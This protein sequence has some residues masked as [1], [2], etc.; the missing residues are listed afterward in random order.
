MVNGRLSTVNRHEFGMLVL[1]NHNRR[2]VRLAKILLDTMDD[3]CPLCQA[4]RPCAA[5]SC[6]TPPSASP[7]PPAGC[8]PSWSHP[9]GSDSLLNIH[10]IHILSTQHYVLYLLIIYSIS[11]TH[12]VTD[13]FILGSRVDHN[14]HWTLD[15]CTHNLRC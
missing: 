15:C 14:L 4:T 10:K 11:S 6:G 8:G 2:A 13:N 7:P 5:P 12:W 1:K 3:Y 9:P